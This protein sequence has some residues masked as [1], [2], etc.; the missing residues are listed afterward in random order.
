M[1][2]GLEDL[3]GGVAQRLRV[4]AAESPRDVASANAAAD[5]RQGERQG[6]RQGGKGRLR[7]SLYLMLYRPLVQALRIGALISC[8][9]V[10]VQNH[11]SAVSMALF[12]IC[13]L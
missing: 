6:E 11:V 5:Q 8:T 2:W 12:K 13:V 7:E 10:P 9:P 3:T 1:L 4:G